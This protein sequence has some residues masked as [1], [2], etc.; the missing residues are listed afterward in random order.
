MEPVRG[1]RILAGVLLVAIVS[2]G[3]ALAQAD[4]AMVNQISG[5]VSYAS[6]GQAAT[7]AKP[8]MRVRQGDRFIVTSGALVRL[9]YFQGAR[10]ETWTGPASFRAGAEAGDAHGSARPAVTILPVAVPQKIARVSELMGAVRLGGVSVRGAARPTRIVLSREQQAE[11]AEARAA[12]RALRA[13]AAPDDLTPELYLFSILYELRQEDEVMIL[14]E[15]MARRAPESQ[16]VREMAA[17]L[18]GQTGRR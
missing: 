9:V 7:K 11:L 10:Q 8:F 14:L 6:E 5:E 4:V 1:I 13:Q 17:W 15:D 12:Y 2:T 16:E 3:P 18:A